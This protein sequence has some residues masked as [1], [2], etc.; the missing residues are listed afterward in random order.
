MIDPRLLLNRSHLCT[1]RV[2]AWF[3]RILS[4]HARCACL[5]TVAIA[6]LWAAG[7]CRAAGMRLEPPVVISVDE[8]QVFQ[9]ITGWEATFEAGQE[10]CSGFD[11]YAA[12]LFDRVVG[13][14]GI[15]RL[16][17]Q[18]NSGA[19]NQTDYWMEMRQGKIDRAT[20]RGLRYAT[21]N[22]NAD[23][24]VIDPD[25]FQFAQLDESID[26]VVLPI[27]QRLEQAGRRLFVNLNY[28]AFTGSIAAGGQYIHDDP[29]EYAEFVLATYL[30]LQSKYGW[31]PDAW[32]VILEPDN[33][34]EWNGTLIGQ[35]IVAAAARLTQAGFQPKFIAPSTTNMGNAVPYFDALAQVPGALT[36]LTEISYHRYAGVSLANLQKIGQRAIQHGLNTAMLEHIGSDYRDL[37]QDLEVGRNSAWQQFTLAF[38]LAQDDGSAYYLVGGNPPVVEASRTRFLKQYFHYIHAGARRIGA[39]TTDQTFAPLAF[40]NPGGDQVVVV[41]AD[42]GGSVT[43]AG[44]APGRYR[45]S[46]TTASDS[47]VE[48]QDVIVGAGE[49]LQASIP[50]AGVLTVFTVPAMSTTTTMPATTTSTTTTTTTSMSPTTTTMPVATCADPDG[51]GVTVSDALFVLQAAVGIRSC[52]ACVCDAD[53]S[54]KVSATDALVV[55]RV[56][57]GAPV[58]LSCPP[59]A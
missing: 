36:Y 6:L 20:W 46:Y 15:N 21:V 58:S 55:L 39:Q 24:N 45:T 12:E 2:A 41:K 37:H 3:P 40:T 34:P 1:F 44:L 8:S 54:G 19:E 18:I 28:V 50:A 49:S 43:V 16:R 42:R 35:A 17:V 53:G 32:E 56:A 47:N 11:S 23:P 52:A 7:S 27:K 5:G 14:L 48:S 57:V 33:I 59:C 4:R 26:R 30:H 13:D 9:T 10:E 29:A 51:D 38:C 25:G 22:D 31:V